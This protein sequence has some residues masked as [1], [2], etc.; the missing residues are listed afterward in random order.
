MNTRKRSTLEPIR[1]KSLKHRG[2]T[3]RAGARQRRRGS[4]LVLIT[5]L[6]VPM[7]A[8]VALSV[9]YGYL[10]KV[11]SDLQRCAD[12]AALACVQDLVPADDGTQDLAAV[13][14]RLRDYVTKN[15]DQSFTVLDADIAIG[16][17]DPTTIYSN[18]TLLNS[19]TADAV[20]VTL[21]RDASANSPVSL[22][23]AP[24]LGIPSAPVTA[25]ATAVLQKPMYLPPGADVLPF[26]VPQNV[27]DSRPI[28]DQW[29]IYGDGKIKNNYGDDLPG[30]W[31]S[32]DIGATS[33]STSDLSVQILDGLRQSDID[34]LYADGR[35]LNDTYI[36][37]SYATFLQADTGLSSGLKSAVQ[38]IQGQTRLVPIYDSNSGA[39]GNNLEFHVVKW[40]VVKVIGSTWS[41]ATDTHV[42]IAK[43]YDY[44]GDLRPN[45]DLGSNTAYVEGAF[46]TPVLVE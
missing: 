18:V 20:R 7:L 15:S 34:A 38:A 16:R 46:T 11:K 13:R 40:G 14:A 1:S 23:I 17:Y 29:S 28:G 31:G 27:W 4:A 5:L 42:T 2:R 22:F 6:I 21:R 36:D 26:S 12:A 37:G 35:I 25:T 45:P 24:V 9:D 41:G 33:N 32:L 19:G 10:L 44:Q 30:N 3:K 39:S 8:M 43:S